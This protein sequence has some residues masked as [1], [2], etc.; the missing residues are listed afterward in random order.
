[1]GVAWPFECLPNF[2]I[3]HRLPSHGPCTPG[4]RANLTTAREPPKVDD[5][6]ANSGPVNLTIVLRRRGS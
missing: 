3:G 2:G 4:E 6:G 5:H 1:M